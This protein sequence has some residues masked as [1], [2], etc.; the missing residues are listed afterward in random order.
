MN[1]VVECLWLVCCLLWYHIEAFFRL[2]VSPP[3]KSIAN[4]VALVTGAGRGIGREI[5]LALAKQGA[6]LAVCD[7][8][9]VT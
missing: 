9:E 4:E 7:V 2:F 1:V 5:A 3:A 6:H 8:N